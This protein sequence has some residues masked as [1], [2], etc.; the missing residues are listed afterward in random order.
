M[1]NN[2]NSELTLIEQVKSGKLWGFPGGVYP[3]ERKTLSNQS[4]IADY[5]P[6]I[7]YLPLKQH[8][9][10]AGELLV[11]KGDKVLKG[12]PLTRPLPG[13]SL[14]IH[15]PCSGV[16]SEIKPHVA[17]HPSGIEELTLIIQPDE[18]DTWFDKNPIQDWQQTERSIINE[19][20]KQ[21]G[22]AGL[23]GASFPTY[24][25][26]APS[27]SIELLIINAVECEPYITADDVL[28]RYHADDII[29]GCEIL[30]RQVNAPH[31][32]IVIENNKP[33]A[34][35]AI[36][37]AAEHISSV[38]VQIIP[39]MYPSGGEKQ[40]IQ[41]VTGRQVPTGG[42]PSDIGLV[43]QNVGTTFAVKRAVVD[44]EPLISRVVTVTGESISAPQN[45]WVPLGTP[46]SELLEVTGFEPEKNQRLIMGGPMM[47][48]AI[49][50]DSMPVVKST[51]CILA[52]NDFHLPPPGLEQECIRCGMCADACPAELLPQQLQWFAKAKEH[53][54]L[55]EYNLFDCIECGACS[56]VCPSQ[57]PLVQ[58]YR[59]GKAEIREADAEKLKSDRAKV[60][61]EQRQERLEREKQE[62]LQRHKEAADKRKKALDKDTSAKDKI[63]A[64][65]A[66]VKAK[67]EG[68]PDEA[69]EQNV[70]QSSENNAK[71]ETA[72]SPQDKVAA[73]IA[74]AKA[75]KAQQQS[76][77]AQ[78]DSGQDETKDKVA[79][80]IAR[81]K[82]KKA[83]KQEDVVNAQENEAQAEPA[84]DDTKDKVAAAIA[85]AK[86]KKAQKQQLQTESTPVI[87]NADSELKDDKKD[88]V[89]A[90]I[91]R[92][93]AKKQSK[94]Q[95]ALAETASSEGKS[96]DLQTNVDEI[97]NAA[98]IERK[99]KIAAA[100]QK[101]KI[102]KQASQ[103][104]T[105]E[106]ETS[107][108]AA[109]ERKAK[110]AAAI[111]KAKAKKQA[112]QDAKDEEVGSNKP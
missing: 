112:L 22:I 61:F 7:V 36:Q 38:Q 103:N 19:H 42:I 75:K 1:G 32:V 23:G 16:I 26:T 99:A 20:I 13:L 43:M 79:A 51:N 65:L 109:D 80:A 45:L 105:N 72:N 41:N 76:D 35:S 31:C 18:L 74:R 100:I 44:G 91:A 10:Q 69:A 71:I 81:A 15:S 78:A 28:M 111:A 66:R 33:E 37:A 93:K 9:G 17:A 88:K 106:D 55:R 24:I 98:E 107:V 30:R 34:I 108:D 6:K 39:T 58:Y 40:L 52:P 5:R 59:I 67:K 46:V 102:K 54:K 27:A 62:R 89:A 8:I 77:N 84:Q 14:P 47:G 94:E 49:M 3:P 73:A 110:V 95:A 21:M 25:K 48:F 101:A 56:Y 29:E 64:A 83:Q 57:I 11:A 4:E 68:K 82:A 87:D 92:A 97:E 63:A 90:A 12:Q 60:R 85:R 50:N 53:E 2:L 104:A 86:A 70:A 96:S